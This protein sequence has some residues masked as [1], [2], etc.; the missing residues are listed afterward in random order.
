[1]H[2]AQVDRLWTKSV[3]EDLSDDEV[4]EVAAALE[5]CLG[6]G[7]DP[8][9]LLWILGRSCAHQHED[10]V[11]EFLKHGHFDD[12]RGAAIKILICHWNL[13]EKYTDHALYF[14][15]MEPMEENDDVKLSGVLC[16]RYLIRSNTKLLDSIQALVNVVRDTDAFSWQSD[17]GYYAFWSVPD[18]RKQVGSPCFAAIGFEIRCKPKCCEQDISERSFEVNDTGSQIGRDFN[19]GN[20]THNND[21]TGRDVMFRNYGIF[22]VD[23]IVK[24]TADAGPSYWIYDSTGAF[25]RKGCHPRAGTVEVAIR[26]L[27]AQGCDAMFNH[28]LETTTEFNSRAGETTVTTTYSNRYQ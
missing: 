4:A 18:A 28:T 5:T 25:N 2:Q 16:L 9:Q 19:K 27:E 14:A 20:T 3:Q 13:T 26:Q 1:M 7:S 24:E 15:R 8:Y 11:A 23:G 12:A 17:R 21:Y 22:W 6:S 10:L